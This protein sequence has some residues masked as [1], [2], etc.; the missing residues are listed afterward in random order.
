MKDV[1][2]ELLRLE[3]SGES[4]V[5]AVVVRAEK[6][7]SAKAGAKA[8]VTEAGEWIGWI[9]GSCS[10]PAVAY[11]ARKVLASGEPRVLHLSPE[12]TCASGG[13]LDIYLEPH[14][15]KP[16]L[17]VIGHL[18]VA[19]ALV[20]LA[21]PLGYRVTVMSPDAERDR[22]ESA[23]VFLDRIDFSE[24]GQ[25]A[26]YVV[27][28]SHGSYDGEAVRAALEAQSAYVTLVSSR[29]RAEVVLKDVPGRENVKVP[30]GLD[31]GAVT[32]EE[33]ALSILA[34]LVSVRRAS[35]AVPQ[36]EPSGYARDPVCGMTVEIE[37]AR[38]TVEDQGTTYYFCG[39]GCKEH[40]SAHA[41]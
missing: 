11:E 8:I 5:L 17:V 27:I 3:A 31:I 33:I 40:F 26:R 14:V 15:P 2:E 1:Y 35:K 30:A 28:A 22:F 10:R 4:F 36:E 39:S 24:M 20:A 16:N 29:K 38:Y 12:D 41:H 34:E 9:G 23:D 19:E 25:G 7:T 21:K 37:T 18:P 13:A 32:P 6:P